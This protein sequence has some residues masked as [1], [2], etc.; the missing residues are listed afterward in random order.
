MDLDTSCESRWV[1]YCLVNSN[2]GT[3]IGATVDRDR[4]LRQHNGLIKGG[5]KA[6]SRTPGDWRRHCFVQGFPDNH[7]ALSFEWRWKRLS[8]KGIYK[9]LEPL[10][11]R[12]EALQELLRLDRPTSTATPYSLYPEPLLVLYE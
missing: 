3:Y 5:A 12:L 8:Q 4:R 2:G 6:T 1:V 9:G 7:A 10:E 11:R